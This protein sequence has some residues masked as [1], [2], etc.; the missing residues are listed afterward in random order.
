M[1]NPSSPS[2][3]ATMDTC[4]AANKCSG[5]DDTKCCDAAYEVKCCNEL[6]KCSIDTVQISTSEGVMTVELYTDTAPNICAWF[7]ELV[8]SGSY[9]NTPFHRIW[10]TFCIQGGSPDRRIPNSTSTAHSDV[11]AKRIQLDEPSGRKHGHGALGAVRRSDD[12][13]IASQQ[14]CIFHRPDNAESCEWLDGKDVVFGQ[15]TDGFETLDRI[16]G[17]STITHPD[18]FGGR[19]S[20]C[21]SSPIIITSMLIINAAASPPE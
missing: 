8:A 16:A 11:E 17:V 6:S 20:T 10:N 19:E 4:C 12:S 5:V 7:L 21:P 3:D 15:L 2:C 13:T 9:I 18:H 1:S 14:F